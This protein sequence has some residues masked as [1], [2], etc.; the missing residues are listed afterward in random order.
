MQF[1]GSA[2][3]TENTST[4]DVSDNTSDMVATITEAEGDAEKIKTLYNGWASFF[5]ASTE[6]E[7]RTLLNGM[8]AG[9]YLDDGRNKADSIDNEL[10]DDGEDEG[11]TSVSISGVSIVGNVSSEEPFTGAG[12]LTTTDA[13]SLSVDGSQ[14][15]IPKGT[16]FTFNSGSMDSL[17]GSNF[18]AVK[19]IVKITAVFG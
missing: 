16:A 2:Y 18:R 8:L 11:L 19:L 13:K 1:Q 10:M 17:L 7:K 6:A 12:T 3:Y 15:I 4:G 9:D 14:V 5:T